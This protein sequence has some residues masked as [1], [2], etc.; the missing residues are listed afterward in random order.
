MRLIAS[1]LAWAS[2]FTREILEEHDKIGEAIS[3]IK[4]GNQEQKL[5]DLG[6]LM[7]ERSARKLIVFP[8]NRVLKSILS[9]KAQA[10]SIIN[11]KW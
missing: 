5:D 11:K 2:F 3:N 8:L 9:L 10:K 6:F 4:D 1:N 7:E